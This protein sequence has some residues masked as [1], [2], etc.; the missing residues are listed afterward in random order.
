MALRM[1]CV[2]LPTFIS[3]KRRTSAGGKFGFSVATVF[4]P[5]RNSGSRTK[6]NHSASRRVSSLQR[7][8][9]ARPVPPAGSSPRAAATSRLGVPSILRE[10]GH[11][12]EPRRPW[13]RP[14]APFRLSDTLS[15]GRGESGEYRQP[16]VP[17]AIGSCPDFPELS[18]L[19]EGYGTD[20]PGENLD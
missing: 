1:N 17:E 10:P 11:P 7:S 5:A 20:T 14:P 15:T 2:S 19:R 18:E 16:D 13:Q 9:S 6:L 3:S 12:T 8:A 4:T